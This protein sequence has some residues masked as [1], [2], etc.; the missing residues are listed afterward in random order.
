MAS[1]AVP[2]TAA[3]QVDSSTLRPPAPAMTRPPVVDNKDDPALEL[4]TLPPADQVVN[5]RQARNL[6]DDTDLVDE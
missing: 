4:D 5:A 2:A 6:P 3:T 1:E